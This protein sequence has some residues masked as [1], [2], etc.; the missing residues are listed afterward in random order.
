MS[1]DFKKGHVDAVAAAIA[2]KLAQIRRIAST[3]D[4]DVRV[5]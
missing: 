5:S 2:N 3:C 4:L 1:F